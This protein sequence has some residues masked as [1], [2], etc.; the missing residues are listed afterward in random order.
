MDVRAFF[1]V[2]ISDRRSALTLKRR[3]ARCSRGVLVLGM[4][5]ATVLGTTRLSAQPSGSSILDWQRFVAE[6]ELHTI[7]RHMA[8]SMEPRWPRLDQESTSLATRLMVK[9]REYE[10]ADSGD[11]ETTIDIYAGLV[12]GV[13]RAQGYWNV[14]LGDTFR[15]IAIA[16]MC[17]ALLQD[18]A[19]HDLVRNLLARFDFPGLDEEVFADI[20]ITDEGIARSQLQPL[21]KG[22]ILG[23]AFALEERD[24]RERLAESAGADQHTSTLLQKQDTAILVWRVIA[25]DMVA[26]LSLAAFLEF[27]RLGGTVKDVRM[28]DV[29]PFNKIMGTRRQAFSYELLGIEA[30]NVGHLWSLKKRFAAGWKD[31]AFYQSAIQ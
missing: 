20:L 26:T 15:R 9:V 6:N 28:D 14:L 18:V 16:R 1:S 21:T 31:S 13:E 19:K 25:T 29:R 22:K 17:N 23:L 8:S 4:I 24:F 27:L 7:A 12:R 3:Q 10:A 30:V 5:V 2:S 11:L